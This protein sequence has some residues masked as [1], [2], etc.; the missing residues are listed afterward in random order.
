[1]VKSSGVNLVIFNPWHAGSVACKE[2]QVAGT[3]K[4]GNRTVHAPPPVPKDNKYAA[5]AEDDKLSKVLHIRLK[6]ADYQQ[7]NEIALKEGKSVAEVAR[8]LL[9]RQLEAIFDW[10]DKSW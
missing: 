1:M 7:L 2:V 10:K 8:S 3:K 4:S 5:K 9:I 6:Q